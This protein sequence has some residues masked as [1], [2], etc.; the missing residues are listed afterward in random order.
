MPWAQSWLQKVLSKDLRQ[1]WLLPGKRVVK[2][3]K[4]N[5]RKKVERRIR[6]DMRYE[7]KRDRR[8][9]RREKKVSKNSRI[10]MIAHFDRVKLSEFA[11]I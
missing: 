1:K 8:K 2:E 9:N 7:R 6:D 10:D 5:R 3:A 11:I 4:R